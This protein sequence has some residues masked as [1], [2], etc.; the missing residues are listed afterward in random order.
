[1]NMYIYNKSKSF[2]GV[3]LHDRGGSYFCGGCE[4][5]QLETGLS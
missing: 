2:N 1:M 3:D 4:P 5:P